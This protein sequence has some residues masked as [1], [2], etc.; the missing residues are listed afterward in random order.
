[1]QGLEY[2]D[3]ASGIRVARLHYTAD[4]DK[5]TPEWLQSAKEGVPNDRIW[6]REYEIDWTVATGLPI[7][8]EQ[9]VRD[10]HVAKEP[11]LAVPGV[12]MYRGWDFGLEP[13]CCWGQLDSA[14]RLRIHAELVTWTGRGPVKQQG[15]EEFGPQVLQLS[16][17]WY[18]GVEWTD[19]ADPAGWSKSQ[20]DEKT[21]VQ[22][23]GKLDIHCRKG[24]M[25]WTARR[26]AMYQALKDAPGG[27]PKLMLS[28]DCTMLIEGF[29][30]AY[31]FE[32]IGDTGRYKEVV[33]KNSWSHVMN[34]LE[35]M[36]GGI[37]GKGERQRD[38]GRRRATP[39]GVTGY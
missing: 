38:G 20:T 26:D 33:E 19:Y 13:A 4:P 34:A 24:P 35:Y 1:M 15:I 28:P 36:V 27:S 8:A 9:F 31:Q 6:R 30:G 32:E 3:T 7:Y 11:I 17:E 22:I 2:R 10:W 12:R 14:G 23:L 21:C 29:E 25:T 18:P 5:R 16:N 37:Y 39:D